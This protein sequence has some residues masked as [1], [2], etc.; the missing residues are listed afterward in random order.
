MIALG[1]NIELPEKLDLTSTFKVK[2]KRLDLEL[3]GIQIMCFMS[4]EHNEGEH[5]MQPALV[6]YDDDKDRFWAV[7]ID[8]KGATEAMVQ[9]GV[10]TIEQSGYIGEKLT[11][12]SDQEPSIVALKKAIAAAR[13]GETVPV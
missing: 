8:A 9:Y 3:H 6:L 7:G 10:G 5:G 12:K 1:A 2:K 13:V 4:G 11:L